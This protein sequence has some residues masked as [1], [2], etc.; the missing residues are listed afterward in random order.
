LKPCKQCTFAC[1]SVTF[2]DN[3]HCENIRIDLN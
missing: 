3:F 2:D 1:I